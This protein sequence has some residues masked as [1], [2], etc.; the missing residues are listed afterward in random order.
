ML[1]VDGEMVTA[2]PRVQPKLRVQVVVD[3]AA[4]KRSFITD[5]GKLI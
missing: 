2:M 5:G 3:V 4:Q 1:D